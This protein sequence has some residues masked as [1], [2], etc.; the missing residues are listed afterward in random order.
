MFW[1]YSLKYIQSCIENACRDTIFPP[2]I[3]ASKSPTISEPKRWSS[4]AEMFLRMTAPHILVH[5]IHGLT[6][7]LGLSKKDARGSSALS[8]RGLGDHTT[9]IFSASYVPQAINNKRSKEEG[10]RGNPDPELRVVPE[11]Q[12]EV[13]LTLL[14]NNEVSN[15]SHE[16]EIAGNGGHPGKEDPRQVRVTD[17]VHKRHLDSVDNGISKANEQ[18]EWDVVEDI[19]AQCHNHDEPYKAAGRIDTDILA[20]GFKSIPWELGLLEDPR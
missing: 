8:R 4:A 1:T 13:L 3:A 15:R 11:S 10:D 9:G 18:S 17:R 7:S 12:F 19:A 20:E 2:N 5:P 6:D 16:R 14:S